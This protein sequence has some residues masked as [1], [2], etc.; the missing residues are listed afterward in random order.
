MSTTTASH[1]RVRRAAAPRAEQQRASTRLGR[2]SEEHT[3][4]VREIVSIPGGGGSTL[5]VDRL[6]G[7]LADAR[8][9]AHLAPEESPEN[10]RITSQM[11]LADERRGRCRRVSVSDLERDPFSSSAIST[12]ASPLPDEALRNADGCL[13][14]IRELSMEGSFPELRWTRSCDPGDEPPVDPL[15]LR[16]VIARF[17]NY[18][19][20]RAITAAALAAHRDDDRLSTVRLR[21]ELERIT[22][23]PIVLNRGLREAVQRALV[24][25]LTMSA[26]ALRCGRAKTDTRGNVS[27]ETSW[28][29]RRIGQLPE[30]GKDEPTP[31][32][33][34]D[35]L[36]LI[37]RD[38][39]G[40]SPREVEV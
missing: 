39:L 35:V 40:V 14:R 2:Y 12:G 8:L 16:D 20:A 36:A 21:G 9:V 29:A 4:A 32:I 3:R 1:T 31:W 37:A 23:S 30:G 28:L 13:Y 26:I 38:G 33:H 10:A 27:G 17:E 11:Y 34:S 19:P 18:E 15:S 5:V 22:A 25:E 24:S 6:A 7:T